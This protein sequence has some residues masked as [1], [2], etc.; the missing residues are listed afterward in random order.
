MVKRKPSKY[1]ILNYKLLKLKY[2]F[3]Q[4]IIT[5]FRFVKSLNLRNIKKKYI[6]QNYFKCGIIRVAIFTKVRSMATLMREHQV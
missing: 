4:I 3:Q 5:K 1:E 2:N 6:L